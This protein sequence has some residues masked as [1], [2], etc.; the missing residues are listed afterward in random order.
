MG[1]SNLLRSVHSEL[2][3]VVSSSVAWD[4]F[5][6][7]G[8]FVAADASARHAAL[9]GNGRSEESCACL[10]DVG[11]YLGHYESELSSLLPDTHTAPNK[12]PHTNWGINHFLLFRLQ[13]DQI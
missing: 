3:C 13:L 7:G 2:D 5:E 6:I 10:P 9:H 8:L 1:V 4:H 11:V 12:H